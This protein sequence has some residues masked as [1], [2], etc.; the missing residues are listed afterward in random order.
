M[1]QE[2]G[3]FDFLEWVKGFYQKHEDYVRK[4]FAPLIKA[5]AKAIYAATA[6]EVGADGALPDNYA[7][8]LQAYE[9]EIVKRH[10]SVSQIEIKDTLQKAVE[11]DAGQV[12]ALQG[13]FDDWQEKRS[14]LIGIDEAVKIANAVAVM[15]FVA[16]GIEYMLTVASSAA[17]DFCRSRAGR[18]IYIGGQRANVKYDI[19]NHKGCRCST[20]A[21][22]E[23][24]KREI[25]HKLPD[26]FIANGIYDRIDKRGIWV[27]R[28]YFNEKGGPK[29]D[30]DLTDH[31][32]SLEHSIIPH[33]HDWDKI[34]GRGKEERSLSA[35][36]FGDLEKYGGD[37][38]E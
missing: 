29:T 24:Y 38:N 31:G 11:E 3:H 5:N 12:E 9:D 27:Q 32:N 37:K 4:Q 23:S 10:V 17:C 22:Q 1:L 19:K 7:E 26:V 16:A 28:R 8:E 14:S 6:A 2:R 18:R 35:E 21:E 20:T 25:A 34:K 30:I 33:A 15:A 13:M 36:E